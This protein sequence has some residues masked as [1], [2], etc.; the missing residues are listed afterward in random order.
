VSVATRSRSKTPDRLAAEA[1]E[2]ARTAAEDLAGSGRVGEHLGVQIDGDRVVTHLFACLDPAY[3][4]WRWAVTVAR[5]PRAKLVTIDESVLLPGEEAVLA[6]DWVP[7]SKRLRPGDI[8]VGDLLPTKEHDL[9]LEPGYAPS[10]N[11]DL[12]EPLEADG[13][14]QLAVELGLT[15]PRVLS[16]LGRDEAADR[17]ADR[18]GPQSA[19]A[20]AAPANCLSCGFLATIGGPFGRAFGVCTNEYAPSD[21]QMV[22]LDY[23]C[24][25]HSEAAVMPDAPAV[26][27]LS[28]D[29]FQIEAVRVRPEPGSVDESEPAEELGHS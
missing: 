11:D 18:F 8:G 23:G 19:M 22:A 3:R 13:P 7:W 16:L 20:Q 27:P 25:G 28:L 12:T 2:L 10:I 9:R 1:V 15:K 4:G 26:P 6:P 21:G 5:A 29:E 17:W 24:G 14:E